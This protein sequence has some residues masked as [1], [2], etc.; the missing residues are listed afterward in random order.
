MIFLPDTFCRILVDKW[1]GFHYNF[2]SLLY[3]LMTIFSLQTLFIGIDTSSSSSFKAALLLKDKE[4]WK[5]DSLQQVTLAEA[6]KLPQQA[7]LTTTL[8]SR[9]ILVK[10]L[11]L[12]LKKERDIQKALPFQMESLLPYPIE[13]CIVDYQI[14]EINTSK[15]RLTTFAVRKDHLAQHLKSFPLNPD[16]VTAPSIALAALMDA[17]FKNDKPQI[18]VHVGQEGLALLVHKKRVLFSRCFAKE[19]LE[20]QKAALSLCAHPT[21]ASIDSLMLFSE[22]K[23][24]AAL[25]EGAVEKRVLIPEGGPEFISYALA[26]GAALAGNEEGS[27][28]FRQK[29]F[30]STRPWK[31]VR[32][33]LITYFTAALLLF[34]AFFG[35][36]KF[37]LHIQEQ[38][39]IQKFC[40]FA[41][42]VSP[43][44]ATRAAL[45]TALSSFENKVA[46]RPDTFPLYPLVPKVS[47][48]LTWL[49]S[50]PQIHDEKGKALLTFQNLYYTMVSRPDLLHKKEHYA[51]KVDMEF[52]ADNPAAAR[53]FHD[54]LLDP[55]N[56]LIDTKKEV[57]WNFGRGIYR[58]SFYLKDKTRYFL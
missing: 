12:P 38:R 14:L 11:D 52:S 2:A 7:I 47:N 41:P 50:I 22:E 42:E 23:S 3:L 33:P 5:V 10:S 48:L 32:K 24:Y 58:T 37:A 44:P 8:S 1:R 35:L 49:S 17:F 30:L 15:S 46:A 40:S 6:E 18:V 45:L 28:N 21:A 31:R 16:C 53:A 25:L 34:S 56:P 54:L 19:K 39:L 43:L 36:E 57:S 51:V 9:E 20:A 13:K 27:V 4:R 55:A 29:E 26:I